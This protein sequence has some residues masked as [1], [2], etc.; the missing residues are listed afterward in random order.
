MSLS[1]IRR[2]AIIYTNAGLLLIG[3]Q[4]TNFNEISIKIQNVSFT[5][6]HLKMSYAKLE[7]ILSRLGGGGG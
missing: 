4:G 6:M 5:T 1:P 3:P 7:A 2:H